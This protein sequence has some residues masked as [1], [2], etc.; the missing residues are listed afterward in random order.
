MKAH[1]TVT[2]TPLLLD[3]N[4]DSVVGIAENTTKVPD[5]TEALW[6]RVVLR[7]DGFDDQVQFRS[8]GWDSYFTGP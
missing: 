4:G 7:V 1:I 6:L 2:R 8:T 5:V 3:I